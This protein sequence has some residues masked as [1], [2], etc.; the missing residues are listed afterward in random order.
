MILKGD[1]SDD[2]QGQNYD[3]MDGRLVGLVGVGCYIWLIL[4]TF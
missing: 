4:G 1:D 3:K 2:I